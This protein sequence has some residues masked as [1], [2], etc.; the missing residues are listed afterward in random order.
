MKTRLGFQLLLAATSVVGSLA[1]AELAARTLRGGAFTF[2]NIF[3]PDARYGVVLTPGATARLRSRT[4]TLTHVAVNP[5]GFR[6]PDW[7]T[8]PAHSRVMVLGDSQMFGYGVEERDA[9]AQQLAV[10][11]HGRWHGLAAAVPTWGPMESVLAAQELIPRHKPERVVFVANLTNDWF[12]APVSNTRRTTAVDGWTTR[13]LANM[14]PPVSFPLRG[15]LF[16]HSHLFYALRTLGQLGAV[17]QPP[18]A[19]A[20]HRLLRE[21]PALQQTPPPH[22][23]RLTP[24]LLA[25]VDLCRSN[26]CKVTLALLPLDVQVHAG[27]WTKYR[28]SPADLSPLSQLTTTLTQEARNHGVDVLDLL[29]ALRAASPGAFLSDDD[30][31]SPGGHR[32]MATALD[33]HFSTSLAEVR[34]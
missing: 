22:Q 15:W 10:V 21:L 16:G 3:E 32:A 11:S 9:V 24:H 33:H 5:Q 2:L 18:I 8:L 1:L 29:P 20:P 6:G 12:E 17:A 4:G 19:D 23:S 28:G 13:V 27:E 7:T 31:L 26:R 30:H 25:V 34:P 14:A